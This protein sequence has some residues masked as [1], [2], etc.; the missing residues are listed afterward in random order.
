MCIRD[1]CYI[2]DK[3]ATPTYAQSF[4]TQSF[5]KTEMYL[6]FEV[7][8]HFSNPEHEID[9]LFNHRPNAILVSTELYRNQRKSWWYFS[10]ESGQH[11]FFYSKKAFEYIAQKYNYNVTF[12]GKYILLS[13]KDY[14]CSL[15]RSILPIILNKYTIPFIRIFIV[16]LPTHGVIKD[17]DRLIKE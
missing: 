4:L 5:E 11:L 17:R 7:L 9:K 12:F 16:L 14:I 13:K 15:V 10:P 8:E 3:Y 1:S 2:N 6:A